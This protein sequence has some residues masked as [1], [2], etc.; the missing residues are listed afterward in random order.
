MASTIFSRRGVITCSIS[1]PHHNMHTYE[2][3]K[4]VCANSERDKYLHYLVVCANSERD[5]YLRYLVV[6]ANSESNVVS[7]RV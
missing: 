5:K 7:L 3:F 1:V 6:C 2:L 4:F